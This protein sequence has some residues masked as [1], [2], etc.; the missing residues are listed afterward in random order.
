MV[1]VGFSTPVMDMEKIT[2]TYA[3]V[4]KLMADVR[5]LGGN[6]LSTR[7]RGLLGKGDWSRVVGNL[8]QLRQADGT[9][10]LTF[11]II[12]G[13]AFRPATT[14]TSSGEAIIRITPNP[15]RK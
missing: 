9:I 5:A 7:R 10:P 6:P 2:V 3:S 13:H 14:V 4:D 8:E 15:N 11:E 12:Y 1:D